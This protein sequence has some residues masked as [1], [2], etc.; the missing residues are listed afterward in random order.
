MLHQV[1]FDE[2][3]QIAIHD[4]CNIRGLI[5]CAVILNAPIVEDVATYLRSPLDLLLTC[6]YGSLCLTP[7]L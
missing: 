6:L 3:I 1:G 4:G 5:A 7:T 2:T